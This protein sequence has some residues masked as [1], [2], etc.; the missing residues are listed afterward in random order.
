MVQVVG[1]FC[2]GADRMYE[3][4]RTQAVTLVG[5]AGN[6]VVEV[7]LDFKFV[8]TYSGYC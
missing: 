2:Y 4:I 7:R 1:C 5:W 3:R 8:R 6:V